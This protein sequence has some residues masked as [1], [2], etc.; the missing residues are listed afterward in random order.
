MQNLSFRNAHNLT[1]FRTYSG[2]QL[3]ASFRSCGCGANRRGWVA[4]AQAHSR[5]A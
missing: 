5:E 1:A 3:L 4:Q 2:K